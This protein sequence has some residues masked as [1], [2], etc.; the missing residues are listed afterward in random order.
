MDHHPQLM[1]PLPWLTS[2]YMYRTSA[3]KGASFVAMALTFDPVWAKCHSLCFHRER[4]PNCSRLEQTG[5][6]WWAT[7]IWF[8]MKTVFTG[9]GI[10]I[11][12]IRPIKPSYLC[13]GNYYTCTILYLSY[14]NKSPEL[15]SV[16]RCLISIGTS[17]C[18]DEMVWDHLLST[19]GL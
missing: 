7:G 16:W 18:R 17:Y 2:W 6:S 5:G 1:S 3:G 14:W 15:N 4:L 13:N 12:K 19:M 9:I 10:P 8:N 11:I